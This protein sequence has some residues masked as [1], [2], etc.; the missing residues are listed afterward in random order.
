[1]RRQIGDQLAI[2]FRVRFRFTGITCRQH[3][4]RA[5]QRVDANPGVVSQCRQACQAR[6]VPGLGER[7]FNKGQVRL[8]RFRDIELAL[9]A[10]FKIDLCQQLAEFF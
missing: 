5:T 8:F 6:S 7:V 3:A 4:R 2:V 1:M 9:R 10:Y